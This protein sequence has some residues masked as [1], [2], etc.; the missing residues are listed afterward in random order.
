M[1][2]AIAEAIP[3]TEDVVAKM[4]A[5]R[6]GI[7]L[8]DSGGTPTYDDKGSYV[9]SRAGYGRH[10]EKNADGWFK[11][12]PR[13]GYRFRVREGRLEVEATINLYHFL[14]DRLTYHHEMQLLYDEFT[15]YS[16]ECCIRDMELFTGGTKLYRY[17]LW[18][19]GVLQPD[20]KAYWFPA[21]W[22]LKVPVNELLP[23]LKPL[24]KSVALPEAA[25]RL[26]PF[27][28]ELLQGLH[29]NKGHF[30]GGY[31]SEDGPDCVYTY[32]SE[33]ALSQDIQY[34]QF[35][36]NGGD[37]FVLLQTHNGC[38]A[39]GGLSMPKAFTDGGDYSLY[40]SS[41]LSLSAGNVYWYSQNGGYSWQASDSGVKDLKDILA[42]ER[43]DA[44]SEGIELPA[45][46]CAIEQGLSMGEDQLKEMVARMPEREEALVKQH[47][48]SVEKMTD[49]LNKLVV[50]L[51]KDYPDVILVH[52][53]RAFFDGCAL[54]VG[55]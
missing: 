42:V 37:A 40:D 21:F 41:N 6:T 34:I 54:E 9:G 23:R 35:S 48:A 31:A 24:E 7:S 28:F 3:S 22:E 30:G 1:S 39:R 45:E 51:S 4:M 18:K 12:A 13:V 10:Y 49:E 14:V 25:A 27:E 19:A 52:G 26:S 8:F 44:E 5:E 38:D 17:L 16:E 2:A 20:D 11:T 29:G 33:N 32:N 55:G 47:L 50:Q 46:L 53:R 43:E 15:A 36:V